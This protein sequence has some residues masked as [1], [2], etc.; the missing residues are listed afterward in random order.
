M[1]AKD[2]DENQANQINALNL[3]GIGCKA[4][5]MR[6]YPGHTAASHVLGFM[7]DGV[8]LAG[9]EGKYDTVL[10]GRNNFV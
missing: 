1:L 4:S 10:Q 7:G 9:V 5:E 8:G 3:P 2:L 6:F